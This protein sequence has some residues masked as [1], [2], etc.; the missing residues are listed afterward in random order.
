MSTETVAFRIA[1]EEHTLFSREAD[2]LGVSPNDYIKQIVEQRKNKIIQIANTDSALMLARLEGKIE[3]L[4]S[5][6]EKLQR[7]LSAAS[8]KSGL[9]GVESKNQSVKSQI[10][11]ALAKK[12]AEY[13]L[14]NLQ[15]QITDLT[16]D[17]D[18][19]EKERNELKAIVDETSKTDR[20][21]ERGAQLL[22]V[23]GRVAPKPVE[24]IMNGLAG[25]LGGGG[26]M[27][28]LEGSSLS[29][30]QTL[31]LSAGT[32]IMQDIQPNVR[33]QVVDL[34]KYMATTPGAI[35]QFVRSKGFQAWF[36]STTQP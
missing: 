6:N 23:A 32:A 26:E 2:E 31:A 13:E 21:M 28:G 19:L 24:R 5:Q 3:V 30:E 14:K 11:E 12:E 16:E 1:K 34:L 20:L 17:R 35:N 36:Q 22:E 4:T 7:D 15:Q 25:L 18:E 29:E 33:T 8:E 27:G 9:N 10:D